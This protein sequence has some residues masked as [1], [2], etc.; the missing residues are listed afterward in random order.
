[1]TVDADA[2]LAD[3]AD[4]GVSKIGPDRLGVRSQ[5]IGTVGLLLEVTWE[6]HLDWIKDDQTPPS[7]PPRL[8][9]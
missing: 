3:R 8:G 1:M 6:H 5:P 4:N 9:M 7:N 2:R